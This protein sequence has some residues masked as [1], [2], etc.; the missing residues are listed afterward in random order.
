MASKSKPR[1]GKCNAC[2]TVEEVSQSE[3]HSSG[4]AKCSRCGARLE[5]LIV[6]KTK[7]DRN[8]LWF[9]NKPEPQAKK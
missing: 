6:P 4:G 8:P 1:H 9:M 3:W 7:W 5:S 2:N